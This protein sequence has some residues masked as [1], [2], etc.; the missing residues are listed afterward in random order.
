MAKKILLPAERLVD[1]NIKIGQRDGTI[2]EKGV[3]LNE[4]Y[5][6][7]NME[8]IGDV[9]S[10]FSAYPDVYLDVIKPQDSSFTLFFYQ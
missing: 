7:A 10:I 3:I 5:L 1:A 6:E 8:K 2:I 9:M 4:N